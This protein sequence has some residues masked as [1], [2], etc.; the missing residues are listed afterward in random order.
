MLTPVPHNDCDVLNKYM[1]ILPRSQAITE[2]CSRDDYIRL[3]T[4]GSKTLDYCASA[5][6]ALENADVLFSSKKIYRPR[7]NVSAI[8]LD[9]VV[10]GPL[11]HSARKTSWRFI[12]VFT[13]SQAVVRSLASA[14]TSPETYALT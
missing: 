9:S 1:T 13:D 4:D 8:T 11:G 5:A 6:I 3:H 2:A 10:H 14:E 12:R 7:E